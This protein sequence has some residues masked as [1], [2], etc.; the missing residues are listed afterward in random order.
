MIENLRPRIR[1][2]TTELISDL[3]TTANLLDD[4]LTPLPARVVGELLGSAVQ[5]IPDLIR[6]AHAINGLYERGGRIS[7]EKALHAEAMLKEMRSFV[8]ILI[9]ERRY[10]KKFGTL[11]GEED[12]LS[13]LV[14]QEDDALAEDEM[15]S[16][17][18]SL[19]VAGHETTTHLL[20]NGM[21]ALLNRPEWFSKIRQDSTLIPMVVEEMAR[22]DGSVPRSWRLTKAETEIGGMKIPVGDLVL[23]MLAAANRDER[24]FENPH[25]FDPFRDN[26]KHLA[27]GKGVH[28]CLGA[29]LARIEAQEVLSLILHHFD[30]IEFAIDPGDLSWREDLALRGLLELPVKLN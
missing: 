22:F 29:P 15:L 6:W 2:I 28:V 8:G 14:M 1:Q 26:K 5:D 18:V 21:F 3:G 27:Y 4:L 7:A 30:N 20:G 11:S 17:M 25:E 12:V 23:P 10:K 24:V 13:A 19:F 9:Q 16:T